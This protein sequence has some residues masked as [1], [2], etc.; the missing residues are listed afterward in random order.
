MAADVNSS[1]VLYRFHAICPRIPD[2]GAGMRTSAPPSPP[3]VRISR[4]EISCPAIFV[5]P[6]KG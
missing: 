2:S 6:R 5:L 4:Y 3:Q 1:L